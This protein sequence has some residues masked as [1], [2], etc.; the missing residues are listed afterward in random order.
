MEQSYA[1]FSD[2]SNYPNWEFY[3]V[4]FQDKKYMKIAKNSYYYELCLHL[5]CK[6]WSYAESNY[7]ILSTYKEVNNLDEWDG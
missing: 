4:N 1:F 7:K 6:D 3:L 5:F 2:Q